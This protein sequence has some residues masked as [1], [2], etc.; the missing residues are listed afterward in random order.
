MAFNHQGLEE[1]VFMIVISDDE[2]H[3]QNCEAILWD[4]KYANNQLCEWFSLPYML[5]PLHN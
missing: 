4:N 1:E 3:W 2:E 5:W